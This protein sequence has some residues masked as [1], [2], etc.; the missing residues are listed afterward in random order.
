MDLIMEC[1]YLA[2]TVNNNGRKMRLEP[3]QLIGATSWLASRW[4]WTP[5]QVRTFLDK[6]EEEGMITR[7]NPG[8]NPRSD[9]CQG[10]TLNGRQEGRSKGRFANVVT[11]SKYAIYQLAHREKGQVERQVS[12]QV[13]G[14][15]AAGSGQVEGHIYKDNKG[16]KEQRNNLASSQQQAP[17]V[18]AGLNGAAYSMIESVRGWLGNSDEKSAR[19]WLGTTIDSFGEDATKAA[20]QKL[21]TEIAEGKTFARPLQ[22]W[23]ASARRMCGKARDAEKEKRD[24]LLKAQRDKIRAE[25]GWT[26]GGANG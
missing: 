1:R 24:L 25:M 8:I 20:F 19:Q 18:L 6:L 22:V 23:S 17:D 13:E 12:G 5:K 3:G 7:Q 16:T 9:E 21:Q 26:D 4:N 2:G 10:E 15:L 14:Q 11:V